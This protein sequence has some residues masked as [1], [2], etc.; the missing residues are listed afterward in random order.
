MKKTK[1]QVPLPP[2]CEGK[3]LAPETMV[4]ADDPRLNEL[5]MTDRDMK[6][7]EKSLHGALSKSEKFFSWNDHW[8]LAKNQ[9]A[10]P[11][12]KVKEAEKHTQKP[13]NPAA[14]SVL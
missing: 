2:D 5:P 1:P 6:T 7:L 10:A 13:H 4:K 9:A 11:E 8:Q 12:E 3:G 14:P